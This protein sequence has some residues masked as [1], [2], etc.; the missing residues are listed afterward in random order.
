MWQPYLDVIRQKCSQALHILD[1]FHVVAKMNKALDDVRAAE[2]RKM[3]QDDYP[4][5]LRRRAGVGSSAK[6]ISPRSKSSVCEIYSTT[7]ST[8]SVPICS[9]KIFSSTGNTNAHLCPHVPGFLVPSN[10][11]I[12]HRADEEDRPNVALSSRAAAQPLFQSQKTDFQRC[13]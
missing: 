13:A 11:A 9:K 7:T 10:G 6:R 5:V 2:S 3:A 12:P 8:P 1:R 4:S